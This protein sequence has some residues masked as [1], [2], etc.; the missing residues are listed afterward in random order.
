LPSPTFQNEAGRQTGVNREA[1]SDRLLAA[2]TQAAVI[3][4]GD[5]LAITT[6]SATAGATDVL[7]SG[8]TFSIDGGTT[9]LTA[10]AGILAVNAEGPG[11]DEDPVV[12]GVTF[13][14]TN[15]WTDL[16]ETSALSQT[17]GGAG[18]TGD[19]EYDILIGNLDRTD[20]ATYELSGLTADTNYV[21]Q[22]WYVDVRQTTRHV[23][24]AGINPLTL[25]AKDWEY[26]NGI[27][28]ADGTT[29][30]LNITT[31]DTGKVH[32]SGIQVREYSG[33][34]PPLPPPPEFFSRMIS[35]RPTLV[36][37]AL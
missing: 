19:S 18:T 26:G 37:Q 33:A 20:S 17:L 9:T 27:F 28:T 16:N 3:T 13:P 15:L 34:A 30:D 12:D 29:Q 11:G 1:K 35:A 4:W 31:N 2:P 14:D 36:E 6:G 10:G 24:L 5:T 25:M 22:V 8:D 21:V 23:E 7:K 32:L